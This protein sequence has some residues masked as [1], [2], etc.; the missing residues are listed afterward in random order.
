MSVTFRGGCRR[1]VRGVLRRVSAGGSGPAYVIHQIAIRAHGV[2]AVRVTQALD[3]GVRR[4]VAEG[5]GATTHAVRV[6]QALDAAP[7]RRVAVRS[8][9]RVALHATRAASHATIGRG[10]AGEVH[11]AVAVREA[12]DTLPRRRAIRVGAAALRIAGADDARMRRHAARP[13]GSATRVAVRVAEAL[14]AALRCGVAVG[15]R[16]GAHAR[17][18]ARGGVRGRS[19]VGRAA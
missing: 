18:H 10:V 9:G 16:A 8:R 19:R 6:G 12:R 14:H 13:H 1:A 2:G 5:Q 17:R 11:S 15:S 7:R 4:G 3:A